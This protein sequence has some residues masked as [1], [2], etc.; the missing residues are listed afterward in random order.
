VQLH[1]IKKKGEKLA[2]LKPPVYLDPPIVVMHPLRGFLATVDD[3][4][5]QEDRLGEGSGS[6]DEV[7]RCGASGDEDLMSDDSEGW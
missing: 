7:D 2:R 3:N 4:E 5:D 1:A 6:E